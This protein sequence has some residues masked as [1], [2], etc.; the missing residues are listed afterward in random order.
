V[1]GALAVP[2]ANVPLRLFGGAHYLVLE[3]RAEAYWDGDDPWPAFRRLLEDHREW[4]RALVTE[5]GVQTNEVR[6]SWVL[7]PGVL[8][9]RPDELV[10]VVELGPSAG[11]NLVFDRYAYRYLHGSWGRD[12]SGLVLT[13]REHTLV[14]RQVLARKVRVRRRIGI[15]RDPVDATS[16]DG[17]RLLQAFVWPDQPERLARVR[18]A[19]ELLREDPPQLLRGDFV[20]LL[21]DV[22]ER[23]MPTVI[24]DSNATEY[25]DDERFALLAR[26]VEEAGRDTPLA[27][28]S[29]ELPRSEPITGYVLE[30]QS[31][32]G[33][34]RRRLAHVHYHGAWLDWTGV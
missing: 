30:A 16:E 34:V 19:I 3:G 22:V 29:V 13:G 14:P 33:G 12:H 1:N 11:L 26:R 23:G 17:A 9:A 24:F 18:R 20:D 15:D 10:D 27:W 32:P 28:V 25:L 6:R 2:R 7:L 5:Q 21:P 31:W 8:A 4:L